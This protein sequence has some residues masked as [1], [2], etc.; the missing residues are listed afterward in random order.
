MYTIVNGQNAPVNNSLS[1]S[2][3]AYDTPSIGTNKGWLIAA[4][5]I[6]IIAVLVSG[7]FLYKNVS[8]ESKR[9]KESFGYRLY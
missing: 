9:A 5:I 7:Y 2:F 3:E 8:S 6:S 4:F 1:V